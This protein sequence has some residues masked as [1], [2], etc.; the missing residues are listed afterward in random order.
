M[1]PNLDGNG[2]TL[3]TTGT[4]DSKRAGVVLI[5]GEGLPTKVG[6]GALDLPEDVWIDMENR[7]LRSG[8]RYSTVTRVRLGVV[9][10]HRRHLQGND[11]TYSVGGTI[12]SKG[13]RSPD[14]EVEHVGIVKLSES[15]F[16]PDGETAAW[17]V[18]DEAGKKYLMTMP[19]GI[20]SDDFVESLKRFFP[21]E[22]QV[23][24]VSAGVYTA[25]EELV[26]PG[27]ALVIDD[28]EPET[29]QPPL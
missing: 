11:S 15:N 3:E 10:L 22:F 21:G 18:M 14:E 12:F 7:D 16:D 27:W 5:R 20:D 9:A 26:A 17:L 8:S 19:Y 2:E 29:P 13:T 25:A 1:R 28:R 24:S 6:V 4:L 23:S